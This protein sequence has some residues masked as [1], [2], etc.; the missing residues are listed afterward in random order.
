MSAVCSIL[1]DVTRFNIFSSCFYDN[2]SYISCA[3]WH[4]GD[5]AQGFPIQFHFAAIIETPDIMHGEQRLVNDDKFVYVLS[6]YDIARSREATVH[7]FNWTFRIWDII[8]QAEPPLDS[9]K[10]P[11]YQPPRE[12]CILHYDGKIYVFPNIRDRWINNFSVCFDIL[13]NIIY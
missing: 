6:G 8:Y 1:S 2:L 12:K 11:E 3:L 10:L 7:R 13:L 4:L 5:M 9:V